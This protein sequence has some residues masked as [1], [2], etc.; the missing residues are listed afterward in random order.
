[1]G[2]R[3]GE[4][5]GDS[6]KGPFLRPERSTYLQGSWSAW[7]CMCW[8]RGVCCWLLECR[9]EQAVQHAAAVSNKASS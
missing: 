1:M 2:T 5:G 4:G 3:G 8:L 6:C 7:M 9:R